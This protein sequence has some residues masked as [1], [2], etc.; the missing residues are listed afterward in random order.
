MKVVP[1]P[2]EGLRIGL[3]L[4]FSVRD[5]VGSVLLSKGST[6]Q[7]DKQLQLL[8][9]REVFIDEIE[10]ESV[11]RAWNAQLDKML[12][13]DVALGRIAGAHVEFDGLAMPGARPPTAS[14]TA[15]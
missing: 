4:P 11:Q 6:I 13:K 3:P 2:S 8:Q 5:G 1:L 9:S 15:R 10:M 12:R 14:R 7:T